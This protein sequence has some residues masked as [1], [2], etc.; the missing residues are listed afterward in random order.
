MST[1]TLIYIGIAI[2]GTAGGWLGSM[3]DGGNLFGLWSI[4][5]STVGG[6]LGIWVGF[7]IGNS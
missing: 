4:L 5:G 3:L 1:K 7:K 2:F 6:L